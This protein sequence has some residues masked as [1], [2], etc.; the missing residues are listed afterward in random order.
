MTMAAAPAVPAGAGSYL[1][2][3]VI[4]ISTT[5]LL[6]IVAMVVLFVLAILLPFPGADEAPPPRHED[7]S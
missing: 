3:G 7:L 6:I 2:W 1:H 5:N 4:S